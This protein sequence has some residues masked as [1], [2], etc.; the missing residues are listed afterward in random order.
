MPTSIYL[1]QPAAKM[2]ATPNDQIIDREEREKKLTSEKPTGSKFFDV[3]SPPK[4]KGMGSGPS[5][6]TMP[7][8]N[9]FNAIIDAFDKDEGAAGAK[10][11]AVPAMVARMVAVSLAMMS[12]VL[13]SLLL[14]RFY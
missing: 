3:F 1:S 4:L 8:A 12:N 2:K 11:V 9:S 6:P 7:L 5:P 10:A 13:F 14:L